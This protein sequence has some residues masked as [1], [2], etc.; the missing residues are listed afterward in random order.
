MSDRGGTRSRGPGHGCGGG[1]PP[2]RGRGI[3]GPALRGRDAHMLGTPRGGPSLPSSH[4]TTIG[5]KRPSFSTTKKA[6]K[7]I[8]NHLEVRILQGIMY[9]YDGKIRILFY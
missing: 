2:R 5:T 9:H 4:D 8:S 7:V 1:A 6:T 3:G